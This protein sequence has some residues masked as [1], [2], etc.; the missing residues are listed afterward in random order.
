M[1]EGIPCVWGE[2]DPEEDVHGVLS[3]QKLSYRQVAYTSPDSSQ[4]SAE[5]KAKHES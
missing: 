3:G 2:D 5:R 1:S 4:I